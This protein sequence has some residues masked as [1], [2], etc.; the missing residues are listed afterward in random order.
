MYKLRDESQI[1]ALSATVGNAEEMADWLD[2]RLIQSDWRPIQLHS[3]TLTGLDV[4]I[5]RIDGPEHTEWPEPRTI[6]GR[7]T[8]RLQSV[9][10]D[11][12]ASGGQMLVHC[13][14]SLAQ[15]LVSSSC[16]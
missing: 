12:V 7:T 8:K 14:P 16:F 2:A 13:L 9:L 3:G 5:H 10:D 11:S 4:K 6:E 15:Q 1:I